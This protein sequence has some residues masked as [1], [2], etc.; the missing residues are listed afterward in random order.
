MSKIIQI[1]ILGKVS[2][3]VNADEVIGNRITLKKM[4]SSSGEV[5]PFVSARAIKYAIRQEFKE[6]GYAIDP[7]EENKEATEQ[8]RLSDSADP[9]K[10][11][12]NDLFGFMVT[13]SKSQNQ[14]GKAYKRHAPIAVSYFKALKD[15]PITSEFAARFPR[16]SEKGSDPVPFEVEV[17]EFIGRLMF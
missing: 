13:T 4:Y 16:S 14:K 11:I 2:G 6:R 17:A 15:T 5:L 10:F 9:N 3:N 1:S 12:D 7:F 8:L